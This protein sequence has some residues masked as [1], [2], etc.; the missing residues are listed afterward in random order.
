MR[1]HWNT[2]LWVYVQKISFGVLLTHSKWPLKVV[3]NFIQTISSS[4]CLLKYFNV[5]DLMHGSSVYVRLM[6]EPR[7][8]LTTLALGQS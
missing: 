2:R 4:D 1:K 5:A 6:S 7:G 8:T 3:T